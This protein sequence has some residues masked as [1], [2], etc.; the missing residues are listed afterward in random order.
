ML[1][2]MQINFDFKGLKICQQMA[3]VKSSI[4]SLK[5][6]CFL[7]IKEIIAFLLTATD[8]QYLMTLWKVKYPFLN[9]SSTLTQ[10][11]NLISV[12]NKSQ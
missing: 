9:L 11:F 7:L 10:K 1:I 5:L 12:V 4:E 3:E 2:F 8:K 6:L